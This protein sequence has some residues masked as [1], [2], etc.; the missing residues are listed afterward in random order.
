MIPELNIKRAQ[1]KEE[2]L[3][4]LSMGGYKIICGGTDLIVNLRKKDK[5]D[6]DL[7]D[8][9]SVKELR[10]IREENGKI[11]LGSGTTISDI[12][13]S[14]LIENKAPLLRKSVENAGCLQVRNR[15][16]IGGNIVNASPAA[17]SVPA[18]CVLD[19]E[20][21]LAS[22]KGRRVMKL[23]E[24]ITGAY[25]SAVAD[26]ELLEEVSFSPLPEGATY[27]FIKLARRET[28][29]ISRLN[30]ALYL[31]IKDGVI[32]KASISPGSVMP[33]PRRVGEAEELLIGEKPSIEL[34]RE[35]GKKVGEV[36]VEKSGV[37]WSTE[38]K[39]PVI[40]VLVR[41]ALSEAAGLKE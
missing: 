36:M 31:V 41:R 9:S 16:S 14:S 2:V 18:L 5:V 30:V 1:G 11:C 19:A 15:A 28:L 25:R 22:S 6:Y 35:V 8:I 40:E 13:A 4:I 17:D 27:S 7:V 10:Y 39:K 29:A 20:V 38:Y 3:Q 21:S 24:F 32:E 33:S 34:F 37:R 23:E 26:D 12:I